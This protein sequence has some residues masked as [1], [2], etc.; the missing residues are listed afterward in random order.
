[1]KNN[2]DGFGNGLVW[3]IRKKR[4]R[5]FCRVLLEYTGV[6]FLFTFL[7]N[8]LCLLCLLSCCDFKIY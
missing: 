3:N 8:R 6:L 4:I 7:A 2:D 5:T 1:M